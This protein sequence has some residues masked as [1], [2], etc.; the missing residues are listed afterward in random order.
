MESPAGSIYKC[1]QSGIE[2]KLTSNTNHKKFLDITSYAPFAYGV[3][4]LA[5]IL[6]FSLIYAAAFAGDFKGDS[7]NYV[8]ALYFSVVTVTTLGYGD[9]TPRLDSVPLLLA[10]IAQVV[11]GVL[12]IGLFLNS[13]SHKL[14]ERKDLAQKE[15]E[16]EV[17]RNSLKKL[18]TILRPALV[19]YMEVLS[20]TYKVTTTKDTG[21]FVKIFPKDLFFQDYYDQIS[22]QNFFS[23]ETRYGVGVMTWGEFIEQ[24]NTRF[25]DR[26][27]DFLNKFAT[28]LPIDLI[29]LLVSLKEHSFL[30]HCKQAKQM[31]QV[32]RD[33]GNMFPR[34]HLLTIEH[35]SVN[36]PEKPNSIRDFHEKLL[37]LIA[38]LDENT[39]G[40]R[41]S[42][43]VDLRK[44]VTAPSIGSAIAEII[45]FGPFEPKNN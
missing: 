19:K 2:A 32:E 25:T 20:E 11:L 9:L 8:Q 22:R 18:L 23:K 41:I 42:M 35:S 38:K 5:N 17:E 36:I 15:F 14:S 40:E 4:Y 6:I 43:T 3:I 27:D 44:G 24:E 10:V 12:T 21:D 33:L 28:S 29:E 16:E 45:K 7:V 31:S 39:L 26:I 1:S 37:S 34:V 13:I 30:H